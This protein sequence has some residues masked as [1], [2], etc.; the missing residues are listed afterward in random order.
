MLCTDPHGRNGYR[1]IKSSRRLGT[2]KC[3]ISALY[4]A[5]MV[6]FMAFMAFGLGRPII[7]RRHD[8]FAAAGTAHPRRHGILPS[9][10]YFA[11]R[12]M[13]HSC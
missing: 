1:W 6:G 7:R 12:L 5:V 2:G 13:R 9:R 3:R 11:C 10:V 4:D 8:P